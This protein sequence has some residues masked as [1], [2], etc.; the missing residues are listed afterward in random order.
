MRT[1]EALKDDFPLRDVRLVIHEAEDV[2]SKPQRPSGGNTGVSI[3]K[4][5]TSVYMLGGDMKLTPR[6]LST[7]E[8]LSRE[9]WFFYPYN[10][11]QVA[12]SPSSLPFP[13]SDSEEFT[14][15]E[16]SK[17]FKAGHLPVSKKQRDNHLRSHYHRNKMMDAQMFGDSY[18]TW[19]YFDCR[20]YRVHEQQQQQLLRSSRLGHYHRRRQKRD[21]YFTQL[22]DSGQQ[23]KRA[24]EL[25]RR[26]S[27]DDG[28]SSHFQRTSNNINNN[29]N[30]ASNEDSNSINQTHTWLASYT[31]WFPI[32]GLKENRR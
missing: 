28:E 22:D 16:G 10:N 29:N 8:E 1:I 12:P 31:A 18:F 17:F 30:V 11:P 24:E 15:K 6:H 3:G 19:P 14:P 5:T 9:P 21:V 7:I 4:G 2:T 27:D 13:S 20:G 25:V 32:G 23:E 26:G